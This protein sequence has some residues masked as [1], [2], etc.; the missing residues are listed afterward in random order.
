MAYRIRYRQI[1]SFIQP[2]FIFLGLNPI[3]VRKRSQ[4]APMGILRSMDKYLLDRENRGAFK[5]LLQSLYGNKLDAIGLNSNSNQETIQL[6]QKLVS[7]LALDAKVS[8]LRKALIEYATDYIGYQ[9]DHQIKTK[10]IDQN[11]IVTALAVAVDELGQPFVDALRA[12]FLESRDATFRNRALSALGNAINEKIARET[13]EW[14]LSRKLRDNEWYPIL[15]SQLSNNETRDAAWKWVK[16]N[17]N[18][19]IE[20]IPTWRQGQIVNTGSFFC[21]I[22]RHN[23]VKEFF[24]KMIKNLEGGPRSLANMLESIDLCVASVKH[25][26]A[27]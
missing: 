10:G 18:G 2:L 16:A 20:R 5:Q 4:L 8:E 25:N 23:E 12:R 6:R 15:Y 17:I 27:A 24:A 14:I 21:S 1:K 9:D 22:E 7:F 13:R 3:K 11:I 26:S 19:L